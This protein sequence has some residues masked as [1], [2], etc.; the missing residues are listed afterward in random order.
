MQGIL[1]HRRIPAEIQGE[2]LQT[3]NMG[4]QAAEH[5]QADKLQKVCMCPAWVK[6]VAL[7]GKEKTAPAA[8]SLAEQV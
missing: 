5:G 1:Q 7:V 3:W 4:R 6:H 8:E 2:K